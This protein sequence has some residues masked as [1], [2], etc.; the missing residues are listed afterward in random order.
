ME[1]QKKLFLAEFQ[2]TFALVSMFTALTSEDRE[3]CVE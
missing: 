2:Q 3:T 1:I